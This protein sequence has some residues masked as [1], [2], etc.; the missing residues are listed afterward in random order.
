MKR[1]IY[2][3]AFIPAIA[4]AQPAAPQFCISPTL[5]QTLA[6]ALQQ[7]TAMLALLNDAAQEP[8]RQA[9]A[10]AAAVA[11]Q[12]TDDETAVKAGAAAEPRATPEHAPD[13]ASS[14]PP[15]QST[16]P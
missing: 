1:L 11:K 15:S 7:D 10:M 12:K 5:A 9:A 16:R 3:A 14:A 8:Q 4:F 6:T 2:V 13:V